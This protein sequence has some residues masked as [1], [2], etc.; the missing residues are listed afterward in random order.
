MR[1]VLSVLLLVLVGGGC[2]G[3]VDAPMIAG[4]WDQESMGPGSSFQMILRANG[5]TISGTGDWSGEACCA[6]SVSVTGTIH[7]VAVHLDIAQTGIPV[8]N[9]LSHFDGVLA[10][11]FLLNG[12]LVRDGSNTSFPITYQR[13]QT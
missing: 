1:S 11:P 4:R 9:G 12:T 13:P 7:G 2:S 3:V 5:S 8:G 6:G 10:S